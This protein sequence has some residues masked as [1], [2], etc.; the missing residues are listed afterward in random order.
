MKKVKLRK[1]AKGNWRNMVRG[2]SNIEKLA[3]ELSKSFEGGVDEIKIRIFTDD[4]KEAVELKKRVEGKLGSGYGYFLTEEE[5]FGENY[6]TRYTLRVRKSL[7]FD[8]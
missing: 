8:F 3:K 1:S 2:S 4:R 5:M 7:G 6:K